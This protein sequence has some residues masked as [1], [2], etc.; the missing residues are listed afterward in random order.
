[1]RWEVY[2]AESVNGKGNGGFAYLYDLS[3]HVA[4]VGGAGLNGKTNKSLRKFSP[5]LGIAD[6]WK[7]QTLI[8]MGY[9]A[10]FDIGV[11]GT[12]FGPVVTQNLPVLANQDVSDSSQFGSTNDRRAVFTL[13]TGPQALQPITIPSDGILPFRG[14][15][16]NVDPRVRPKTL[17]LPTLDAWNVTVQRQVTPT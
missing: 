3:I 6:P 10:S 11:F 15:D 5:P 14:P 1:L 7:P 12:T 16:N 13:A 4:G 17:R 2:F 9:G 8:R